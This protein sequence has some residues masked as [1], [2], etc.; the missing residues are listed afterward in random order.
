M[1]AQDRPSYWSNRDGVS[2]IL[3]DVRPDLTSCHIGGVFSKSVGREPSSLKSLT[4]P[5]N[6][7]TGPAPN[8]LA[9][10]EPSGQF[11]SQY[12]MVSSDTIGKTEWHC[13]QD[14]PTPS[15]RERDSAFGLSHW[16]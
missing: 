12:R 6:L 4:T 8:E 9:T 13:A 15:L 7:R 14:P 1:S 16:E 11:L 10:H 2:L 5:S 3:P